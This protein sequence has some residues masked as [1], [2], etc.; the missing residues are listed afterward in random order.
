M[1]INIHKRVNCWCVANEL[2]LFGGNLKL[3]HKLH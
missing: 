2:T 1:S 3:F